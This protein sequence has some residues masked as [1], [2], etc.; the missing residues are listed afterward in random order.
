MIRKP[1]IVGMLLCLA[2][3]HSRKPTTIVIW[4]T[5]YVRW[6]LKPEVCTR[7]GSMSRGDRLSLSQCENMA[8]EIEP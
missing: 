4:S 5:P 6:C 7:C 1:G 3:I 8:K 2:G